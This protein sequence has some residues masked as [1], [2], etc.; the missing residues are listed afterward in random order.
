MAQT[1]D[2]EKSIGGIGYPRLEDGDL[3]VT[4]LTG[5]NT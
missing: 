3:R 2:H 4:E 5:I 1:R